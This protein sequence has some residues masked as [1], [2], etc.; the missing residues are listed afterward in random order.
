M[1]HAASRMLVAVG[2]NPIVGL[3]I[4]PINPPVDARSITV[5]QVPRLPCMRPRD[6]SLCLPKT[7]SALPDR[8][9]GL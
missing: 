4:Y 8:S 7:P 5:P 1:P 2:R 6:N 3:D 9:Y